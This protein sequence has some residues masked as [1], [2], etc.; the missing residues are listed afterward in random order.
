[1]QMNGGRTHQDAVT[2]SGA[3][4]AT[5]ASTITFSRKAGT[6]GDH[7]MFVIDGPRALA[8]GGT[9]T[10]TESTNSRPTSPLRPIP[11]PLERTTKRLSGS[12][13]ESSPGRIQ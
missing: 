11:R 5:S 13:F 10:R 1:M 7:V 2:L 9:I 12:A 8:G 6:H 4:P 3:G